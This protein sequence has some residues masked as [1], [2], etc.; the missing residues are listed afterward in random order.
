MIGE[1]WNA[2]PMGCQCR[3]RVLKCHPSVPLHTA[4]SDQ[5]ETNSK[6]AER[7]GSYICNFEQV[8]DL[9]RDQEAGKQK[10]ERFSTIRILAHSLMAVRMGMPAAPAT[11]A[12]AGPTAC[13]LGVAASGTAVRMHA[14]PAAAAGAAAAAVGAMLSMLHMVMTLWVP[15][16]AATAAVACT[17]APG[18]LLVLVC[19]IMLVV[20][21]VLLLL[22]VSRAACCQGRA[23]CLVAVHTMAA[24]VVVRAAATAARFR[25]AA[26]AAVVVV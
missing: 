1:E 19:M 14:V 9:N 10:T 5:T 21:V 4:P 13:K 7:F 3:D 25:P 6:A 2:Q 23:C 8:A 16:R 20:V 18:S 24:V 26:V 11:A 12:A 15:R 22:V 17:A